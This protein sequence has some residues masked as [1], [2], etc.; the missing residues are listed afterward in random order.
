M[1]SLETTRNAF[2]WPILFFPTRFLIVFFFLSIITTK[3]DE[4]ATDSANGLMY[5]LLQFFR[6]NSFL[7]GS[8]LHV[9]TFQFNY[10]VMQPLT[11]HLF[12]TNFVLALGIAARIPIRMRLNLSLHVLTT[13]A[14]FVIL[15]FLIISALY[16]LS[17]T[18]S[19]VQFQI[20][21]VASCILGLISM[22]WAAFDSRKLYPHAMIK[23]MARWIW[24]RNG[25]CRTVVFLH[26][27]FILTAMIM[28]YAIVEYF[29]PRESSFYIPFFL[30]VLLA[31]YSLLDRIVNAITSANKFA[32][33][34]DVPSISRTFFSSS[35]WNS[36]VEKGI[37]DHDISIIIFSRQSR[38]NFLER[39][40]MLLDS[41]VSKIGMTVEV[42]I[43]SLD[44]PGE[45]YNTIERLRP[46]MSGC[47][48]KVVTIDT[49]EDLSSIESAIRGSRGEIL[50]LIDDRSVI[51]SDFLLKVVRDFDNPG[52]SLT[53][54]K[55]QILTSSSVL[56]KLFATYTN[57]VHYDTA[58]KSFIPLELNLFIAVRKSTLDRLPVI[59]F[60]IK[61][62][63]VAVKAAGQVILF[64]DRCTL[65]YFPPESFED[66]RQEF[67]RRELSKLEKFHVRAAY[68]MASSSL[69][70]PTIFAGL[71]SFLP[72]LV[73]TSLAYFASLIVTTD[74]LQLTGA[75][76]ISSFFLKATAVSTALLISQWLF[77][78]YLVWLNKI[79]VRSSFV[80]FQLFRILL[81]AVKLESIEYTL[82]WRS[83]S[84]N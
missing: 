15:Q 53:F 8:E 35:V 82:Y 70:T 28:T 55:K 72:I 40:I 44:N 62:L 3:F 43:V 47:C 32:P 73:L 68:P 39:S 80:A 75:A 25:L 79:R 14:A 46:D 48:L 52:V 19:S 4:Y 81:A 6:I 84:R 30:I 54:T 51:D 65:S 60:L 77:F 7:I 33:M 49:P 29:S 26:F 36:G 41:A 10:A 42:I 2:S 21:I 9:G 24:R 56:Q 5:F 38:G 18:S 20:S 27:V 50:F 83:I 1:R 67:L 11:I 66:I 58:N 74:N 71:V 31:I 34:V 69:T 22:A 23:P 78:R 76:T 59:P 37:G 17:V 57:L 63:F 16:S 61:D 64:E 45:V 13:I 12:V